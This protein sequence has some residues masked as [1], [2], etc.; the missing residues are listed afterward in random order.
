M[1]LLSV[2]TA[3]PFLSLQDKTWATSPEWDWCWTGEFWCCGLFLVTTAAPF[4]YF[5]PS[6]PSTVRF[7]RFA[8][9]DEASVNLT[10]VEPL[11]N[12][13][14]ATQCMLA[15]MQPRQHYINWFKPVHNV[16]ETYGFM[17]PAGLPSRLCNVDTTVLEQL[18][19]ATYHFAFLLLFLK[20]VARI[21]WE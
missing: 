20:R 6:S 14:T 10:T 12:Q 18:C 2:H 3:F 16:C 17:L 7:G 1:K 4:H 15:A 11:Q 5:G 13:F 9:F 8:R 19:T 21:A